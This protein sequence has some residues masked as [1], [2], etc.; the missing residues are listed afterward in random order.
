[1]LRRCVSDL[2]WPI[3]RGDRISDWDDFVFRL[4]KSCGFVFFYRTQGLT[5]M[6]VDLQFLALLSSNYQMWNS[7]PKSGFRVW[8]ASRFDRDAGG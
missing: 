2:D 4:D 1:V 8:N 6:T 3:V 7:I 5:L